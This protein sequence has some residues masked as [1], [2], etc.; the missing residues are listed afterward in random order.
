MKNS[1]VAA[2]NFEVNTELHSLQGQIL[3]SS[4]I[5]LTIVLN[6]KVLC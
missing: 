2:K 4:N 1:T 6:F 5:S 3:E